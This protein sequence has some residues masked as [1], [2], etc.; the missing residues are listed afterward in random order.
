VVAGHLVRQ[1]MLVGIN[2]GM[3]SIKP[4]IHTTAQ[5]STARSTC[6]DWS[7]QSVWHAWNACVGLGKQPNHSPC[8]R[9][10]ELLSNHQL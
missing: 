8:Q 1:V 10:L 5:H 2:Q 6:Q 3:C 4:A 7:A 9:L